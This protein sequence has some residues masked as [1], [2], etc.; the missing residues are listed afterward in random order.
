MLNPYVLAN[1]LAL[2]VACGVNPALAADAAGGF[3]VR[4]CTSA[5]SY[6]V[7]YDKA[8]DSRDPTNRSANADRILLGN[9]SADE[10]VWDAGVFAGYRLG[11]PVFLDI[12]ADFTTHRGRVYGHLPGEGSSPGRNRLGEVGPED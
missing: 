5:M 11:G 2:A 6:D 9:A 3:Y 4:V 12:E 10:I 8:V 7:D 1:T